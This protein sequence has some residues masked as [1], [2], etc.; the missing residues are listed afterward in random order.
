MLFGKG[1]L[2]SIFPLRIM[3]TSPFSTSLTNEAPIISSAHVSEA[4]I[5]ASSNFPITSGRIPNGSL[6]PINKP[7]AIIVKA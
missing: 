3:T 7:L 6:A 4:R 5:Y 2:V 1:L